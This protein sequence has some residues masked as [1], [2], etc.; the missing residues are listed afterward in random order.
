MRKVYGANVLVKTTGLTEQE[1][2]GYRRLGIG[3][4]DVAGVM[5]LSQY[6]T[7]FSVWMDK[8]EGIV[9]PAGRA[10]H[11]GKMCEDWI[12]QE[13]AVRNG[14]GIKRINAML[15][16]P[17]HP[18]MTA[19]ID[20]MIVKPELAIHEIK[21]INS[22]GRSRKVIDSG[23]LV[24]HELQCRWYQAVLNIDK[25]WISYDLPDAEPV[26]FLV[27][28]DLE[29]ER[30][31]ITVCGAFWK[32]VEDKTPPAMDGSDAADDYLKE[33]FAAKLGTVEMP[34]E[35]GLWITQYES[36]GQTIKEAENMKAQARQRLC[37]MLD[38]T[39]SGRFEDRTVNWKPY[40]SDR[41]DTAALKKGDPAVAAKYIKPSESLRFTIQ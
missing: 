41:I 8:V 1:W 33:R 27:E 31:L 23:I 10:A 34:Q 30:H 7:P 35:A 37:E 14:W 5:G 38:G 29:M 13:A 32:L 21:M 25:T 6:A 20:R 12:A 19:N 16:H 15:Q 40:S 26:D 4:S 17:Q 2:L 11:R 28:R 3:G 36:A 9:R 24:E 18:W 39:Q 22:P